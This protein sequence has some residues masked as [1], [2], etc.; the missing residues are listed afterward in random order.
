MNPAVRDA[1]IRL[2]GSTDYKLMLHHVAEQRNGVAEAL[3]TIDPMDHVNISRF[4]GRVSTYDAVLN[5]VD[6]A[7]DALNESNNK[8]TN[9]G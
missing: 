4:Q 6:E 9:D 3:T 5:L 7:H 1:L 8:G 2:S